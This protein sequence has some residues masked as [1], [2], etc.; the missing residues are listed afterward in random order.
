M[1][2]ILVIGSGGAA[3]STVAAKL[4]Q[5]LDIEVLHL[6]KFYW[7]PRWVE[8]PRE[9]WLQTIRQHSKGKRV[10]WLRSKADVEQ[11]LSNPGGTDVC[12]DSVGTAEADVT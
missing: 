10:V 9:E 8:T 5:L 11:F 4:G 12:S 2:R 7:R 1:K 3:K 6:D